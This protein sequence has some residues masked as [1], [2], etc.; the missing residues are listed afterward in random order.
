MALVAATVSVDAST[1]AVAEPN[2]L[3]LPGWGFAPGGLSFGFGVAT[4]VEGEKLR[5]KPRTAP[6]MI[7]W[8][9]LALACLFFTTIVTGIGRLALFMAAALLIS[10]AS[11]PTNK[12]GKFG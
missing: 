9:T 5:M 2:E 1:V 12:N 11:W 7:A 6:W 3:E 8:S 4:Y 10:A